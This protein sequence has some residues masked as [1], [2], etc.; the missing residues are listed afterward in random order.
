MTD[1][2]LPAPRYRISR[3]TFLKATGAAGVASVTLPSLRSSVAFAASGTTPPGD[4]LVNVFARGGMDGLGAFPPIHPDHGSAEYKA[5][6]PTTYV[7]PADAIDLGNGF[8]MHP[9]LAALKPLWDAGHMAVVHAVGYPIDNRS[10]FSSQAFIDSGTGG[11]DLTSGWL[12]RHFDTRA[13]GNLGL[14]GVGLP[15]AEP[16]LAEAPSTVSMGDI[17]SF[18]INGVPSNANAAAK[19]ALAA[20][21]SASTASPL[22]SGQTAQVLAS[23]DLVTT[24]A[25]ATLAAQNVPLYPAND[26]FGYCMRQIGGLIKAGVGL[27]ASATDAGYGWDL[28]SDYGTTASGNMHDNLLG[29]GNVLAAFYNDLGPT[30]MATT[31]IVVMTEFGRTFRENSSAG[32]DHGRGSVMLVLGGAVKGG[33]VFA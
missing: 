7:D 21:Y 19:T 1:L 11:T 28:H 31:T 14:R 18:R 24:S 17:R 5:A 6:R 30:L 2:D 13:D 9:A 22:L 20:M 23:L 33:Q 15:R 26:Y 4:V 27:E 16:S 10:H 8:G 32:L 3:R 29:L 25:A 12:A